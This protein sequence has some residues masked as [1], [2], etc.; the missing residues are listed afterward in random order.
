M[1]PSHDL[2]ANPPPWHPRVTRTSLRTR[3]SVGNIPCFGTTALRT[4]LRLPKLVL[5]GV[6]GL[7]FGCST[8]HSVE[9]HGQKRHGP[10]GAA[11]HY[12][13][14]RFWGATCRHHWSPLPRPILTSLNDA[15]LEM[16]FGRCIWGNAVAQPLWAMHGALRKTTGNHRW[17]S[18]T[19]AVAT[20]AYRHPPSHCRYFT[21]LHFLIF[22]SVNYV[23]NVA[24]VPGSLL[25]HGNARS[26]C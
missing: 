18:N 2:S 13:C 20:D 1:A 16:H 3:T 5:T 26:D 17:V 24:A 25:Q 12:W 7:F 8:A 14:R 21:S 10:R 4:A 15:D 23:K 9:M 22:T 11:H 6:S 19:C